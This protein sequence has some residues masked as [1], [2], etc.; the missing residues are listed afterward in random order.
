M[1]SS[2][3]VRDDRSSSTQEWT[4]W[5]LSMGNVNRELPFSTL[6]QE[7]SSSTS[8]PSR[9]EFDGKPVLPEQRAH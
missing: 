5:V 9:K 4:P 2:G 6:M 7:A 8:V 3:S 1:G